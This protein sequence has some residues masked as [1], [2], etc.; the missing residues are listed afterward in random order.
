[1]L[2]K[3]LTVL[4]ELLINFALIKMRKKKINFVAVLHVF[5]YMINFDKN[6]NKGRK[7]RRGR[8]IDR[9]KSRKMRPGN[10]YALCLGAQLNGRG[11]L[12]AIFFDQRLLGFFSLIPWGITG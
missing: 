2:L 5:L 1:M 8:A 6:C 12:P 7:S 3:N 9:K 11:S 10:Q 4:T